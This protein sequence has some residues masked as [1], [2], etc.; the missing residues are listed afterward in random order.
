M[1]KENALFKLRACVLLLS[2]GIFMTSCFREDIDARNRPIEE[3]PEE[4][5]VGINAD[6]P[7]S[8][9]ENEGKWVLNTELSDEFE[10]SALNET[11]WLIQ[12]RNGEYQSNFRGRPPSQF[13]TDNVR[14]E[15]GKLKIETRWEPDYNFSPK[16][17]PNTGETFENITTAAVISKKVFKYGYMEIKSKS[18]D[19]EITS[20]FWTTN[21]KTAPIKSE[22]DMFET[23]GGHKTSASW[24]KRLKFNIISWEPSNPYYLPGGNGPVYSDNIQVEHETA[25]NFH[26]YGFEWTSEY[27]KV[28]V[29]GKLHPQGTITKAS[30]TNNGEDPNRWVTDTPYHIWFD[31]E[32]FPWL[33]LPEAAD[34]PVDYEIEYVRVWQKQ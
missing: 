9:Q 28:Y 17:N 29:D 33:G 24:R 22:L 27:V 20:S 6:L 18:A 11:K 10:A 30:L 4:E 13:S 32:T 14:L 8:D 3:N 15:D 31:S 5:E 23:F 25:S 12:G 34:L 19:A 7:L 1:K 2:M 26:V 16:T 21:E